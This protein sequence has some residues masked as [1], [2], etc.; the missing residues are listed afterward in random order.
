MPFSY[1]P[2]KRIET[3]KVLSLKKPISNAPII[4]IISKASEIIP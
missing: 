1:H 3:Q 4:S 2:V